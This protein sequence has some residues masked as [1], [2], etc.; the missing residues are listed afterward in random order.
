MDVVIT[1]RV[2]FSVKILQPPQARVHFH[3]FINGDCCLPVPYILISFIQE[4]R[5]K[6]ALHIGVNLMLIEQSRA[7]QQRDKLE[8]V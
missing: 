7:K 6:P 2:H 1:S 3:H 5:L 8:V 4:N